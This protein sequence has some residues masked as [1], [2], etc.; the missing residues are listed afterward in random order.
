MAFW[1]IFKAPS[2]GK[3]HQ[4]GLHQ[5]VANLL[6]NASDEEHVL[7][8]CVAG[9]CARVVYID[10]EVHKDEIE[11]MKSALDHWTDLPKHDIEAIVE[12]SLDEIK[13][14][15][16]LENHAYAHP[17]KETL[18]L[19][20][21]YGILESLFEIAAS[22]GVVEEKESEEIRVIATGMNLEHKHFISARATVL[23]HLGALKK[24]EP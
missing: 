18:S 8:A 14:L 16:G 1:D 15:A 4:S 22:D 17:L 6:P 11:K 7:V 24:E 23:E 20:N 10:F 13:E 21:R 3:D 12:L 5:K 19:E 9:L 2:Q